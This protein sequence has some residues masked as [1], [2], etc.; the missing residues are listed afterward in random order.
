M[1]LIPLKIPPGVVSD[2]TEYSATG[3]WTAADKVRFRNNEPESIGG[4]QKFS[5]ATAMRGSPRHAR[6][7]R[8]LVSERFFAVG[9]NSKFYVWI[10]EVPWD[11][12]PLRLS[13]VLSA[14]PFTFVS[15]SAEVTVSHLAHGATEGTYVTYAGA[16]PAAGITVSGEYEITSIPSK[17]IGQLQVHF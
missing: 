14:D 12:T 16:T 17:T 5:S 3:F 7:W 8:G 2:G 9:T 13:T 15:G 4:W 1:A 6:A 11:V 10:E